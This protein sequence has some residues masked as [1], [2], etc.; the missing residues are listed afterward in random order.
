MI[1]KVIFELKSNIRAWS[2]QVIDFKAKG[3]NRILV[4]IKD[5]NGEVVVDGRNEKENYDY[6]INIWELLTWQDGYFYKPICYEVDGENRDIKELLAINCRT[7]DE[8]WISSAMLLCRNNRQISER[9]IEKYKSI[10]YKGRKEQSM[11]AA[12]FSSF[13]YLISESYVNINLEHR[14]VLLMHIC[15][16]LSIQFFNGSPKNNSGNININIIL[17]KLDAD[18]YKNGARLLGVEPSKSINALGDTR[19]ELTHFNYKE[20][21]LGSYIENPNTET[22]NMVNLYAFYILENALRISVLEILGIEVADDIKKY[23]MD[24]HL[25]W[26]KLKKHL[27]EDCVLPMNIFRQMIERLQNS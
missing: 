20:N 1:S 21:S 14:L 17:R 16:G 6:I 5:I 22:D 24:D 15:D 3:F 8:K 4:S 13:F 12:I 2:D 26:I 7:T 27:E 25:D 19:N 10:R 11:N 9:I 23:I 18:E